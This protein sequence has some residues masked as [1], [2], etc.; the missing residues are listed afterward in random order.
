MTKE[1]TR[2]IILQE[3]QDKFKLR[4]FEP[5]T[6]TFGEHVV[7]IYDVGSHLLPWSATLYTRSVT[8]TGGVLFHTVPQDERWYISSYDMIFMTGAY[9]V[10]GLYIDRV[11]KEHALALPY[12]DLKPAQSVSYHVEL[13]KLVRLDAGD[14]TY[15]NID[16]YTSTGDLRIVADIIKEEIR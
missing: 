8:G 5:E 9:T 3:I 15:V 11:S 14:S 12:L 2:S 7:P 10:A 6:F 4:E 16:G 1:I 13:M